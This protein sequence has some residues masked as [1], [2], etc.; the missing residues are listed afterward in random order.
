MTLMLERIS[1]VVGGETHLHEL[2]LTLEP[3]SFNV[4]LGRTRAGKT[5]LMRLMA[6]LDRPTAGAIL[7]DGA[8]V[9]RVSR[10]PP[11]RRDG[12]PAVRQLPLLHRLREH[13]LAAAA[14][15]EPKQPNRPPG[16]GD[17]GD[18]AYRRPC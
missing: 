16:A 15:R 4:L 3:G 18:A 6:G 14:G 12:L 1:R 17:G 5:S 9:T 11:Q 2:S 7:V 8:D 10:A 13:R